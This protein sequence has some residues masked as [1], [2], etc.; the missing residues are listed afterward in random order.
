MT[1]VRRAFIRNMLLGTGL[2]YVFPHQLFADSK[3][4]VEHP[5]MPPNTN[6]K[7]VCHNC[8]MTRPMWARTWHTYQ[9]EGNSLDVC[10]LHCLAEATLNAITTPDNVNVALYLEPQKNTPANTAYYVIGSK[11]KGT[12]TMISKLAF[13]TKNDAE[14]FAGECGGRVA[15]FN[16]VYQEAIAS[17]EKENQ[18]INKNRVAKGKIVEPVDNK[19][20][21]PVCGMYPARYPKN[22]CQLQTTDGEV[23]HFCAT[24]CLFEFLK[25][26]E[27]YEQA[28]VKA[29]FIWVIDYESGKWIY[30]RNGYYVVGSSVMGP[31]GK[32]AFPFVRLEDAKAF[33]IKNSGKTTRFQDLTIQ[34]IMT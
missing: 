23:I 16:D 3:C 7:G 26:P 2:M 11:S 1:I 34:L 31:M 32:E 4:D 6:F 17:I 29:K 20:I 27:K 10:S 22:K 5:F 14:S 15:N 12:M 9:S 19:D 21:C 33:S 30:A 28:G 18:M 8:G 13:A 25:R 24:Q